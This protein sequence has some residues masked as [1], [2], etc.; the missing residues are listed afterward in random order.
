MAATSR[1]HRRRL[2]VRRAGQPAPGH[3]Q[4]LHG[5]RAGRHCGAYHLPVGDHRGRHPPDR[6]Q[7]QGRGQD[8]GRA[9]TS[10]M[11]T[12]PATW[13]PMSPGSPTWSR[14]WWTTSPKPT[15]TRKTA[16]TS[17]PA[18]WSRP[19]WRRSSAWPGS[20]GCPS[21]C[22]P[23]PPTCMNGPQTG[24]YHMF[25]AGGVTIAGVD[26]G[27]QQRGHGGLGTPGLRAGGPGAGHQV[28]GALRDP[29][30]AHRLDGHR[31]LHRHPAA[32]S[33]G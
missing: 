19:T 2:G 20:S 15:A 30:P 29:E 28:Q 7:G 18:T 10:S 12:P 13:A 9:N 1:L 8:P 26:R 23:T 31:H 6:R 5:L 14:A 24:K 21:S 11:P 22:S 27:R 33:P 17:F 32:G 3:Q 25:P 4:H 16:S